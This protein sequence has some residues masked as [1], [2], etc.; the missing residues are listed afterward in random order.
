MALKHYF[1]KN[2]INGFL[3]LYYFY[4][5]GRRERKKERGREQRREGGRET[6]RGR[7]EEKERER[8]RGREKGRLVYQQVFC[9]S[10][11]R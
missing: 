8:E 1:L 7:E 6:G 9:L 2:K 5:R 11:I 4:F 10:G 3:C